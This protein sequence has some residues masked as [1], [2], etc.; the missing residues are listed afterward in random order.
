MH[1]EK[2]RH[3][4]RIDDVEC[5][6]KREHIATAILDSDEFNLHRPG[7][8]DVELLSQRCRID[9][10]C[11]GADDPR[12]S[13]HVVEA[14]GDVAD[15]IVVVHMDDRADWLGRLGRHGRGVR[16]SADIEIPSRFEPKLTNDSDDEVSRYEGASPDCEVSD[17]AEN[18]DDSEPADRNCYVP[19]PPGRVTDESV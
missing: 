6:Q 5:G 2:C 16:W 9:V 19:N 15:E 1:L 11:M 7:K 8:E 3:L 18:L 4:E 14:G 10:G 12:E 17:P 13:G